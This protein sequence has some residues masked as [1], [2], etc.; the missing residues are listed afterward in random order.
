MFLIQILLPLTGPGQLLSEELFRKV[1]DELTQRFGGV[2]AYTR[3][4]AEGHWKPDSSETQ[5]D[6][7]VVY[8]V[9]AEKLDTV[10]WRDYRGKLEAQ[11]RQQ[12]IVVRAQEIQL[13]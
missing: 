3:A 2:T 5:R 12:E 7:I 9:M 1:T 8:E 10:W 6:E 4:P 11:F 13:L